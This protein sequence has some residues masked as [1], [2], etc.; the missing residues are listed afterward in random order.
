MTNAIE[1]VGLTKRFG[2]KSVL[3]GLDQAVGWGTTL[4]LFGPNG[5]GKSTLIR[6]LVTLA[7]PTDGRI[8]I[9]GLDPRRDGRRVRRLLGVVTHQTFLYDD[10]T[11][12]ENLRFYARMFRLPDPAARIE[13]L[14]AALGIDSYLHVRTRNLSHGMQK[15]V[16]LARALLHQP[17]VLLLDEPETGLDREALSLLEGL[18]ATHRAEGGTTI[19]TTHSVERGLALADTVAVLARGRIAYERSRAEVD[20]ATFE[21][22]YRTLTG[23]G[24]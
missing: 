23:G 13:S 12:Q 15:R 10:L 17:S 1:A 2:G 6:L 24:T 9:G 8:R 4:A 16:S 22:T 20:A 14:S 3:E 7:Q 18:L 21:E 11:P 5:S 19:V